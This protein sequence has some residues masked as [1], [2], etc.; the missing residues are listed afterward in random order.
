MAGD[1]RTRRVWMRDEIDQE[2]DLGQ[3]LSLLHGNLKT[4]KR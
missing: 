4:L 3:A 1:Q 2:S